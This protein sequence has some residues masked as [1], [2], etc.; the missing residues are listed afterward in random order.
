MM[1]LVLKS[2]IRKSAQPIGILTFQEY[3]HVYSFGSIGMLDFTHP[4]LC[5]FSGNKLLQMV[6]DGTPKCF[7][8]T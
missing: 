1:N 4:T 7:P 2:T 8:T 3:D 5:L 6:A